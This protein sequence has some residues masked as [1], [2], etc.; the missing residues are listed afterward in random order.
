M[1]PFNRD[2]LRESGI[3]EDLLPTKPSDKNWTTTNFFSVWMGSVHNIPNYLAIGGLFALGMSVGQV[4]SSIMLAAL[5]IAA[6]MVLNGHA[7]SKYSLPFSMHVRTVFGIRGAIIPG[8]IRGVIAAILWFGL[9]TFAGSQAL[10]ILIAKMWPGFTELGGNWDLL[11][12]SLPGLIAFLLFWVLNVALIFGGMG[13]LGK[14]TNILSPL[15]YIVFGGMAIWAVNLAG[16]IGPILNYTADGIEGN[17]IIVFLGAIVAVIA[18]WAAPMVNVSDFTK[19]ARSTKAQA[20]GQ[21][22]GLIIAY[23]LFAVASIAIIVGSEIA[24]G[25]PIWNVLDVIDRFDSGFAVGISVLTLCL[26]ALAVNVT[27]N[28][29]PAGYQLASLFPKML[30]FKSGA[31]IAAIIG[32]LILPWKLMENPESILGFLNTVAGLLA[33]ITGIMLAHYFV[34]AKTEIDIDH[35]FSKQGKYH[36]KNGFNYNA[37]ITLVISGVL[38]LIGNFVPFLE[39]L[40]TISWFV[41]I[42]SA[43]IIYL[44]LEKIR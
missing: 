15:V 10:F 12:L 26:T 14:F 16:G 8:I 19:L 43:F 27:G 6:I 25:T 28:I 29:V 20:V 7:G 37:I 34:V 36:Y 39:P 44:L 41:G 17:V 5:I 31:M 1:E 21:S 13:F 32:V 3:S 9:Q 4:F 24:F 40:Y 22:L 2:K 35:L 11:G 33:P 30:N 18:A 23:L 42:I 38:S